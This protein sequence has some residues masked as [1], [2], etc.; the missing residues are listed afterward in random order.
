MA[1]AGVPVEFLGRASKW[2][3]LQA[4][5]QLRQGLARQGPDVVQSMLHH[6]NVATQLAWGQRGPWCA[7]IRVADPSRWRQWLE[8]RAMGSARKVVCVSQQVARYAQQRMAVPDSRT[9]V[10]PNGIDVDLSRRQS[11]A[12]LLSLGMPSSQRAITCIARWH[13]RRPSISC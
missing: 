1:Q 12:D 13:A 11:P 5:R 2:S 7:G 3:L 10:I 8:R 6:A 9:I 4:V